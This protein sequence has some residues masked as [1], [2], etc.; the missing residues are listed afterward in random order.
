M[1]SLRF[2]Q[3]SDLH[4]DGSLSGSRLGLPPAKRDDVRRGVEAALDRAVRLAV[5][6]EV[7]VVFCPGDLWD[8]E[9]VSL[10]AAT[11]LYDAFASLAPVPVLVAP[12]NHDPWHALSYHHRAFFARKV[13][14]PHPANVHVFTPGGV[15]HMPVPGLGDVAFHGVSFEGNVP[16]TYRVL[17]G[18]A[19]V[20]ADALSV[21]L[22][23]GSRDDVVPPGDAMRPV[24][25]PFTAAE[26][27]ATGFDY[28]A[29]GHYHSHSTITDSA[30]RV[31]AA[32]AGCVAARGLDETG[33][34]G[35]LVGEI[36]RGGVVPGTLELVSVEPRRVVRLRVEV[37]SSVTH[38]AALQARVGAAMAGAGAGRDDIVY[39]ELTGRTHPDAPQPTVDPAWAD[40]AAF[41]IE[42]DHRRLEPD[43]DMDALPSERLEGAFAR[44]MT[45]LIRSETDEAARDRLRHAL[46]L[47]L[48]ALHD[49]E[50]RPRRAY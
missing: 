36:D 22:L 43:Y 18:A 33:P 45:D 28:V 13:G 27:L 47:G 8:D 34:H 32:Y 41:H 42:L 21:L 3:F 37:D 11:R 5:D 31:R 44:R 46:Y 19:P 29:L 12:G 38:A 48:D 25:A 6:R 20:R 2:L 1:P 14:R 9:S 24:T 4:L 15:C 10:A 35:A 30:G 26:L 50:V 49:R 17:A 40:S 23:H 7:D 16:R 39:V